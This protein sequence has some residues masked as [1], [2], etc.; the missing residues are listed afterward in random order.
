MSRSATELSSPLIKMLNDG[1]LAEVLK[2][3]EEVYVPEVNFIAISPTKDVY[4]YFNS[5]INYMDSN[6]ENIEMQFI[7]LN[8][9][10]TVEVIEKNGWIQEYNWNWGIRDKQKP[11]V[12]SNNGDIFYTIW[13]ENK[14]YLKKYSNG[15]TTELTTGNGITIEAFFTDGTDIFYLGRNFTQDNNAYFL[16]HVSASDGKVTNIFY[17]ANTN[18]WIRDVKQTDIGLLIHGDGIPNPQDSTKVYSGLLNLKKVNDQWKIEKIVT[19]SLSGYNKNIK[20]SIFTDSNGNLDNELINIFFKRFFTDGIIPEGFDPFKS[21][22]IPYDNSYNKF[23]ETEKE[24]LYKLLSEYNTFDITYLEAISSIHD[25]FGDPVKDLI[26][27]LFSKSNDFYYWQIKNE[28]L[29]NDG[30]TVRTDIDIVSEV[31]NTDYL[32]SVS[33]KAGAT[34]PKYF[35]NN[36]YES[37]NDKI[38][39]LLNYEIKTHTPSLSAYGLFA[40]SYENGSYTANQAFDTPERIINKLREINISETITWRK[41]EYNNNLILDKNSVIP[42]DLYNYEIE[43]EWEGNGS[44]VYNKNSDWGKYRLL[45]SNYNSKT[46]SAFFNVAPRIYNKNEIIKSDNPYGYSKTG[47]EYT[48]KEQYITNNNLDSLIIDKLIS[49]FPFSSYAMN[50]NNNIN[51]LKSIIGNDQDVS[52][53]LTAKFSLIKYSLPAF[54]DSSTLYN[55]IEDTQADTDSF[56]N[57]YDLQNFI[58]TEKTKDIYGIFLDSTPT[59]SSYSLVKLYNKDKLAIK[60]VIRNDIKTNNIKVADNC[61][62]YSNHNNNGRYS[63]SK[64]ELTSGSQPETLLDYSENLELYK[65]DISPTENKI[66]FTALNYASSTEV[67]GSID[68]INKQISYNEKS[69]TNVNNITIYE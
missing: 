16:R 64:L 52:T 55:F 38:L 20:R 42:R 47:R 13:S 31:V 61:I 26:N 50:I 33:I 32:S 39:S 28:F 34:F 51:E 27:T 35:I 19:D 6:N 2:F 57:Y 4:V 5:A 30:K 1:S 65:Y 45:N 67:I 44:E 53:M 66:Y 22:T 24:L 18:L 12:F 48:C 54:F 68:I 15:I 58:Y 40:Y 46:L 25:N 8:P 56:I 7:K 36:T 29:E 49:K 17:S 43:W 60:E 11:I 23:V 59:N 21:I 37:L 62:Y 14:F 69:I 41:D 9:D 10:N 63:L 3:P